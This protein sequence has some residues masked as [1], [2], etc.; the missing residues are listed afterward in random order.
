MIKIAGAPAKNCF[1]AKET[2]LQAPI[3][4]FNKGEEPRGKRGGGVDRCR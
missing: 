1:L 3:S 4:M 2:L